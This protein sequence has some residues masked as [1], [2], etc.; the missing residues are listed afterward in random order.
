MWGV[1]RDSCL[2]DGGDFGDDHLFDGMVDPEIEDELLCDEVEN[3]AAGRIGGPKIRD[4]KRIGSQLVGAVQ[5]FSLTTFAEVDEKIYGRGGEDRFIARRLVTAMARFQLSEG[6][7]FPGFNGVDFLGRRF[8]PSRGRAFELVEVDLNVPPFAGGETGKGLLDF[9]D[10]HWAETWRWSLVRQAR[11]AVLRL[12]GRVLRHVALAI[13]GGLGR[14]AAE[15][16][17]LAFAG[18]VDAGH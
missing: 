8:F 16:A 11:E 17:V 4:Q 6:R 14:V 18:A 1:G 15:F 9:D 12:G 5:K 7:E 10:A 13:A 3:L 2:F